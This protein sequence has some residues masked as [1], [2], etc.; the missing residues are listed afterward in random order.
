MQKT[1]LAILPV[2][3]TVLNGCQSVDIRSADAPPPTHRVL[4]TTPSGEALTDFFAGVEPDLRKAE[5]FRTSAGNLIGSCSQGKGE[6]FLRR[7]GSLLGIASTVH[8]SLCPG[9]SD[10]PCLGCNHYPYTADCSGGCGGGTY[11]LPNQNWEYQ[12]SG[13]RDSSTYQCALQ[14]GCNVE[15]CSNGS[16]C[17]C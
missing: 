12:C 2:C 11:T 6:S 13:T 4:M 5:L 3:G 16:A 7:A 10:P 17:G 15:H 8:A 14:C 9:S 1:W